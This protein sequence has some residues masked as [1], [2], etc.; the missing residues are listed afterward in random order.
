MNQLP[1]PYSNC[2]RLEQRAATVVPIDKLDGPERFH[3]VV[4]RIDR[5]APLPAHHPSLVTRRCVG[6]GGRF[7]HRWF[8]RKR[9]SLPRGG[10]RAVVFFGFGIGGRG[11]GELGRGGGGGRERDDCRD[12]FERRSRAG[13]HQGG[14]S[15]A[16]TQRHHRPRLASTGAIDVNMKWEEHFVIMMK[17]MFLRYATVT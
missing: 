10:I 7:E 4:I 12:F 16:D 15:R 2:L 14:V 6:P 1:L 11:H 13:E 5:P 17:I 3:V 9:G 8:E